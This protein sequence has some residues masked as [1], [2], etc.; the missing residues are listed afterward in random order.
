MLLKEGM[1]SLVNCLEPE[2][3]YTISL[4]EVVFFGLGALKECEG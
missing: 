1:F 2:T 4:L 3:G